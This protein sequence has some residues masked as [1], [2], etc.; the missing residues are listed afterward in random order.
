[1][2]AP[3]ELPIVLADYGMAPPENPVAAIDPRVT[4]EFPIF[5]DLQ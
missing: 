3:G 4:I 2:P 5:M 1:L